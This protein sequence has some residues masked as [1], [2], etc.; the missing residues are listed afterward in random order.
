MTDTQSPAPLMEVRNLSKSYRVSGGHRLVAVD[1]ISL[2]VMPGEMLGLVGESGCG[3]STLGRCMLRLTDISAGQ[4]VFEGRDITTLPERRLRPLRP[5]MQM[6][7]QDSSACLNPRRRIGDL[8]AEPLRVHPGPDQRRRQAADIERR[9]RD[10]MELV[11]L[12]VTALM[13]YPHEFSGGQRQRINIARALALSPRLVVADEPVSAL[14]VSVQAQI[15]NLFSDLRTRLGLTYVFVAHDLAVVRQVSTRVAV[16][17]LGAI[18]E[19]GATDDVLHQPAHPYTAALTTAVPRPVV[20]ATPPPPLGGD[21]PSPVNR[22]AGCRFHTR[23]PYVQ[24]RCRMEAPV[25]RPIRPGHEAACHF[26]LPPS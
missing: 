24:D 19:M 23:C 22:P 20:G 15:V 11:S 17:Y 7:F 21:I 9:V 14:D 13:R 18:V 8:L 16:M 2:S 3:K 25:L 6:V 1:G 4:V 10:L 26:P 5:R 12:P